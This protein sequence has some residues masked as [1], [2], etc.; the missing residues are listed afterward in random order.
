MSALDERFP[1]IG[2]GS[3]I[4]L[5]RVW[6]IKKPRLS[7]ALIRAAEGARTLDLLHGK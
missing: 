4:Y 6:A 2:P 7:G 1:A 3:A 5:R